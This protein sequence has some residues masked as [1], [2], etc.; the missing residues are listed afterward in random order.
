LSTIWALTDREAEYVISEAPS[1]IN[2][3]LRFHNIDAQGRAQGAV[4]WLHGLGATADD[5]VPL[6][7]HL[8]ASHL[9]FF[10]PQAPTRPV[11]VNMGVAMPA[12][13]DIRTIRRG[14]ERENEQHID[15]ARDEIN[16]ILEQLETEGIPSQQIVLAGFSQGAA[17]ALQVG[18]R[19]PRPLAGMLILSGY[20]VLKDRLALEAAP[21]NKSTPIQFCHG[22]RDPVVPIGT[23]RESYLLLEKDPRDIRWLDYPMGHEVCDPQVQDIKEWLAERLPNQRGDFDHD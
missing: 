3:S 17:M 14:P 13:Y 16:S 9:R 11:T 20:L 12:W 5:F 22:S 1:S 10:F 19:Y 7:P 6:V 18:L 4:V 2:T 21:A 23:A 15:E 8:D